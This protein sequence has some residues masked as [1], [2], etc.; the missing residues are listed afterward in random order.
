MFLNV[1]LFFVQYYI[2]FST[3]QFTLLYLKLSY[4]VRK[5]YQFL[6]YLCHCCEQLVWILR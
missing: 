3:V 4:F 6:C 1:Q 5:Y 2:A